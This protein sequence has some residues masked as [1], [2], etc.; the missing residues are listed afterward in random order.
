MGKCSYVVRLGEKKM[1]RVGL[2][3]EKV[4]ERA[5][6]LANEKGIEA[7]TITTLAQYLGIKKPSLYNH[8]EGPEDLRRQI[9]LYGWKYISGCMVENI[10][11]EDPNEEL[12]EVTEG[13]YQFFFEQTD[14]LGIN[15]VMANHLLRTYRALLEGFLLLVVHD[16]FGNP[17][18]IEESFEVTMDVFIRGIE[19]YEEQKM[20][21]EKEITMN[22][23]KIE[24]TRLILR[25]HEEK[26]FADML[27]Y[28]SDEEVVAFE[29]YMPMGPMR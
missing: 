18:S 3:R 6:E 27:E 23:P 5:A 14:K 17:V 25:R 4:I 2:T 15:R 22:I 13:L 1:P 7:V 28:L 8:I 19:Q 24:T 21:T 9:M 29:P 12:R 16:S 20:R 10:K 26:D 11:E